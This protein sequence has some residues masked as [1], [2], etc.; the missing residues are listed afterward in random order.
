MVASKYEFVMQ[1]LAGMVSENIARKQKIS[2]NKAFF[3]LMR[4][5]TGEMLFDDSLD[6]WMSGPDYIADE[7][8]R[9]MQAKRKQ[10]G[11]AP[12]IGASIG[13]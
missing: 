8:R 11:A 5:K 3:K 13:A 2:K 7:Y 1:L 12:S 9:E 6:L 4:S 10:K